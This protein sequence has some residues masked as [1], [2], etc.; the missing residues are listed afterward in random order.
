[1]LTNAYG[2]HCP[3]TES[4]NRL[5]EKSGIKSMSEYNDLPEWE[6]NAFWEY[7]K[8]MAYRWSRRYACHCQGY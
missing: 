6:Y 1:M 4:L 2:E 8:L 7:A 5:I 3:H